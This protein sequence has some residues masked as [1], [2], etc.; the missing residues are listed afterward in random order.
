MVLKNNQYQIQNVPV[1][2]I[3]Q[4]HGS[5]LYVYDADKIVEKIN[6]LKSA[7]STVNLKIKFACKALTNISI[8]KLMRQQGVELDVVSPQEMQLGLLAGYSGS[9][10]TFTP[11][12]VSFDEIQ[13]AVAQGSTVNLDNLSVLEKF[14][15]QYGNTVDC[16]L[17]IKPNVA[18]GGNAKIMTAHESSKFGIDVGQKAQILELIKKYDIQV[19]GIHQHT[20]SDI[21]TPE[22][23]VQ[24][25]DIIFEF[26]H[27]FPNLQF[28]DLGGGFK[29]AYK[30]GDV[31]TNMVELGE[32]LSTAFLGFCGKYGRPLQLWF[33]PGKFLVSECGHLFVT[34]SVVK[35]NPTRTFVGVNSG[36]N[37]LIRPMMYDAY[38]D[39]VNVSNTNLTA[40]ETYDVVGYIC[41]TDT[42]A[43]DRTLPTV[44]EGDIL[45]FK[46]AGAYGF[47]MSS[48][49]N[50]RFRPAEVLVINGQ[51]KVI[52][53]R[54][55]MEDILGRQVVLDI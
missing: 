45:A 39:I 24:V 20:G 16:S 52:R 42:F 19:I 2:D 29:V 11:S 47:T 43:K 51:A 6:E 13:T 4:Q 50:S 44:S 41:E 17:R 7:F 22:A 10:I 14:G 3:V 15:Q 9:Q 40:T 28:I 30:D 48:Q 54:E 18:A 49:Y 33:E 1:L 5:P 12:G 35:H 37:H 38:H 34:A 36:L 53:E 46:N 26:A 31:V 21:K 25:A 8:L 27:A 55:T 23:F 32:Q